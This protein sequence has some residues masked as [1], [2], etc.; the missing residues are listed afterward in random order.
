MLTGHDA[1]KALVRLLHVN[2]GRITLSGDYMRDTD[3]ELRG[4]YVE[5][6]RDC[7]TGAVELILR[8]P[9]DTEIHDVGNVTLTPV[10]AL[11][12]GTGG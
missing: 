1:Q 11:P 4:A 5:A 12:A 9:A 2:G 7:R 6:V 8:R 3:R 10:L